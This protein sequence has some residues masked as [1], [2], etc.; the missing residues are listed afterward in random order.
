MARW[1]MLV[2][3]SKC[4]GCDTCN[5]VC[6]Q[7]NRVPPGR[8]FRQLFEG[9]VEENSGGRRLFVTTNCMH[10]GDPPCLN[11]CPS[12]ATK[13][14]TDGIVYIDYDS[15]MGCG[16]CVVACPYKARSIADED[17]VV[18]CGP[19]GSLGAANNEGRD[20]IGVCIKCD[21]CLERLD[22]GLAKGLK[23]G[24]DP[25]ATPMCVRYCISEALYFGDAD[26]STSQ[27]SRMISENR[28]VR[29]GE[30]LG[31][32]PSVYYIVE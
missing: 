6:A 3:L 16:S 22:R 29:L 21:F 31:T 23:P 5:H 13:Q 10:C 11:V 30:D 9:P 24:I 28:V 26:D 19:A 4:I 18:G 7:T 27:V 25:E 20:L 14:R 2:D 32:K 17:V 12:G 8:R 1:V 15:C